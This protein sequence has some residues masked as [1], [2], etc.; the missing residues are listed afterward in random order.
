MASDRLFGTDGIRGAFGRAPLDRAT[1]HAAGQALATQLRAA[2]GPTR[3][4]LG[5]DTRDSTPTLCQWLIAGLADGGLD[6]A[7]DVVHL[8]TA[9]TPCLAFAV[10]HDAAIGAG[11]AVSASHNPHPDNGI[12]LLAADGGKWTKVDEA[13]L[14]DALRTIRSALDPAALPAPAPLPAVDDA[15]HEAYLAHLVA[16]AGDAMD[17]AGDDPSSRPLVGLHVVL[18]AAYGAASPIAG[19]LFTRLGAT[20]TVLH[21]APD[22]R[23][24]NRGAGSTHPEA[25]TAAVR[26]RAAQLSRDV[27]VIGF[28]FDGDADRAILVDADGAI[29]DGDAMLYLWARALDARDALPGKAI[30]ATSMSNLG[31][32]DALAAVDIAVVRCDVGDRAVVETLRARGLALGGEQSGHLVHLAHGPTGDGLRTAII[33]AADLLRGGRPLTQRLAAF[34]R[35]PQRLENVRVAAKPALD[36]LPRVVAA[37]QRVE[38]ALGRRGRLVLRYSGTEPLV[39]IMIEASDRATIDTLTA[40]LAAVLTEEIGA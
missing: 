27:P 4:V 6:P 9:T 30:V 7:R 1:V 10:A 22:G 28:A 37:R 17:L 19:P 25:L 26:A 38:D 40:E 2:D 3:V 39:R 13:A 31:L 23:N 8:G 29:R 20:T 35:Y 36:T 33:L 15:M 34:R 18:D 24:I 12:K 16:V 14:E 32:E 5:G 11:V 21:D